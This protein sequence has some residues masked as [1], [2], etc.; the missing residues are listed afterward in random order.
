MKNDKL[1]ET[2]DIDKKQP[3]DSN[4]HNSVTQDLPVC[5][6]KDK[7]CNNRWI[8]ANSDCV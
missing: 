5:D 8:I 2:S 6:I 1:V 3:T 7:D 4:I